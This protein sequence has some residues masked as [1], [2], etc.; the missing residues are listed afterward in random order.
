MTARVAIVTGGAKRI[1]KGIVLRLHA[2]GFSICLHCR[3]SRTEADA[4]AAQL[5]AKRAD[6]VRVCVAD[7]SNVQ[8]VNGAGLGQRCRHV[9]EFCYGA[10]GRCDVLVNN[11]SA[12]MET[13]LLL[14]PAEPATR[15][16]KG[17][18]PRVEDDV[19]DLMGSNA[20]APFYLIRAFARCAVDAGREEPEASAA[21]P[22]PHATP[23]ARTH[24]VVNLVDSMTNQP[25]H[26]LT[27]YTM[28]KHALEGLTK[29][30]AVEL[31]PVHIRVNAVAPGLC[32]MPPVMT[33]DEKAVLRSKVPLGQREGSVEEIASAVSFLASSEAKYIT[34]TTINVDGG[35]SL[36]RA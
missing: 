19:S 10:F 2:D 23:T 15:D 28:G 11:A 35:W 24:C 22:A 17:S 20:L 4:L 1:G 13:P 34:G 16:G 27:V 33:E 25:L 9:I 5:N 8:E 6:S 36:T 31:A 3:N 30:A 12:Y 18:T 29:C 26:G 14:A 7:L 32:V 21:D